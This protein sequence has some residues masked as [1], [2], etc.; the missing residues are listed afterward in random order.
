MFGTTSR[1]DS[2]PGGLNG[3]AAFCYDQDRNAPAY[4]AAF[5]EGTTNPATLPASVNYVRTTTALNAAQVIALRRTLALGYPSLTPAECQTYWGGPPFSG[6]YTA[7]EASSVNFTAARIANLFLWCV[8]QYPAGTASDATIDSFLNAVVRTTLTPRARLMYAGYRQALNGT[9]ILASTLTVS[10]ASATYIKV[11]S[12]LL[13]GPFTTSATGLGYTFRATRLITLNNANTYVNASNVVITSMQAGGSFY[14]RI[15]ASAYG[16]TITVGGT[17]Q[18]PDIANICRYTPVNNTRTVQSILSVG[19]ATRAITATT[20]FDAVD[21]TGTLTLTGTKVVASGSITGQT[22]TFTATDTF[23]GATKTVAGTTASGGTS[24]TFDTLYYTAADV[25]T[26]T[27]VITET[28]RTGWANDTGSITLYVKVTDNRD[29][30]PLVVELYTNSAATTAATLPGAITFSNSVIPGRLRVSK[31]LADTSD[32]TAF[33]YTLRDSSNAVVNYTTGGRSIAKVSGSGTLAQSAPALGQFTLT[34]DTLIEISGLEPGNYTISENA[35]GYQITYTV[36]GGAASSSANDSATIGNVDVN[37]DGT[38]AV[39]FT[40][41]RIPGRLTVSKTV[42]GGSTTQT[43][44]FTVLRGGTAVDLAATGITLTPSGSGTYTG[45]NL[46]AGQF[47]LTDG[48]MVTING[49]PPG[50]TYTV[51]ESAATG[52]TTQYRIGTSGSWTAGA[53]SSNVNVISGGSVTVQ[54]LNTKQEVSVTLKALKNT[55]GAPMEEGQFEFELYDLESWLLKDVPL[56]KADNNAP[57]DSG[58]KSEVHFDPLV[59]TKPGEYIYF[60]TETGSHAGWAMDATRYRIYIRVYED[61]AD[62]GKLKAE[63]TYIESDD[64]GEHFP[65]R[66]LKQYDE[67]LLLFWPTF[68]NTYDGPIFPEVGGSGITPFLASGL[69]MAGILSVLYGAFTYNQRKRRRLL[70]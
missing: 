32:N 59:F 68:T 28:A 61:N 23:N 6:L 44:T 19:S 29:G 66:V 58:T 14:V 31:V 7:A 53:T 17:Q 55:E 50:T 26:H 51:V 13:Y 47:T 30:S 15:P 3:R 25:G 67:T 46:A 45:T 27:L 64:D 62:G 60:L 69:A 22:F 18:V 42:T 1:V 20:T 5:I 49:L 11:G 40:N 38:A 70:E 57:T 56:Q 37:S 10:G 54:F 41:T 8:Q 52:Y 12:D 21:P 63:V 24:I 4:G 48:A 16:T 9:D 43:F 36:N 34:R 39:V 65:D 35:T 33:T 2:F